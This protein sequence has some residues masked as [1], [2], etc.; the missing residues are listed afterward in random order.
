MQQRRYDCYANF[1]VKINLLGG[2]LY[3]QKEIANL[4]KHVLS[5]ALR[6]IENKTDE[7]SSKIYKQF[8]DEAAIMKTRLN[9]AEAFIN[10]E[11]EKAAQYLKQGKHYMQDKAHNAK[12][13]VKDAYT[14]LTEP[15]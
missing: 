12:E 9:T 1:L 3:K 14:D 15:R 13:R 7:T 2:L 5:R 11:K 6:Q 10:A 4:D 8:E